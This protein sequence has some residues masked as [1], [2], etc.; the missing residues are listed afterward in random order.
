MR[1]ITAA[2]L[3]LRK[4]SLN[5][6]QTHVGQLLDEFGLDQQQLDALQRIRLL[7]FRQQIKPLKEMV[8]AD[9]D[10]TPTAIMLLIAMPARG[11]VRH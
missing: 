10:H 3:K 4:Q 9:P 8:A 2:S 1:D 6:S 7:P 11:L 5:V